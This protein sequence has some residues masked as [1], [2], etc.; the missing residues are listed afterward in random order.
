M[1]LR[2][3]YLALCLAGAILPYWQ[4]VPWVQAHGLDPQ[5]LLEELFFWVSRSSCFC[6]SEN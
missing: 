4:L 3:L 6:G 2:H 5:L 1:R